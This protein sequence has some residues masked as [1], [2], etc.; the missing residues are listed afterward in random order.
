[1]EIAEFIMSC[2]LYFPLLVVAALAIGW[3]ANAQYD[4]T[5]GQGIQTGIIPN[6]PYRSCNTSNGAYR[7][8]PI[9]APL[10]GNQY[11]FTIQVNQDAQSCSGPCC[12]SGLHKIEFNVS[13]SCL[14]AGSSVTAT[15]NGVPTRV[16]AVFDKP[17]YGLPG[18]AVLRITQLGLDPV[19]A[20][21]AQLCITLKP[22]RARQGCTTL[23]QLCS[24]PGFPAG[25]CT[26]A[27][28]DV[29]CDCCPVTQVVQAQPPP[30]PPVVPMYR[31]CELCV[32]AK[33]V[34][35]ANDVR[36]YRFDAATCATIQQNIADAMN[37]ALNVS[38]I[39]P[40]FAPFSPNST[41]CFNDTVLTCGL[42]NGLEVSTLESLFIEVSGLLSSFIEVAAGGSVCNPRLEGYSVEITTDG[43]SCLDVSQSAS[44]FL[45]QTPFPNCTCNITKG[46]LPFTV[47]ATYSQVKN[48]SNFTLSDEYCF[49]IAALPPT[50]PIV[51]STC[52][53][54]NDTIAKLE[55][56]ADDNVRSYVK[57]FVLYPAVGPVKKVSPSWG[58]VGA[59]TLKVSLNWTNE[60]ANGGLV[61]VAIRQP[62]TMDNVCMDPPSNQCYVSI[63]N[64]DD[65]NNNDYCCPTFR[66]GP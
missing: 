40:V 48:S 25:T 49:T 7:L 17:P 60:Q 45:P 52:Y 39:S 1:R 38:S 61:C 50:V 32:A 42:F 23:E 26:A 21:G 65:N 37:A 12:T 66:S 6:F 55:W 30:P 36:P 58:A 35:P 20:Q 62:Y 11:C 8:A 3:V 4:D 57:G 10:G 33:L 64:R 59:N 54:E 29:A 41:N 5:E 63:F 44:C 18:S 24:S 19:T 9:W 15:L 46:V 22:N 31:Y 51:K 28:F 13:I 34:P 14:V 47:A 56:Y 16:G 43:N 27:T 2:K 53:Q